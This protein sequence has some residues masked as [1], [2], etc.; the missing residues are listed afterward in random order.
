MGFDLTAK[1]SKQDA[2]FNWFA[3]RHILEATGAGYVLGFGYID[4]GRYVYSTGNNGS[5]MSNDGYKVTSFE[6]KCMAKCCRG[7][8]SVQRFLLEEAK[9]Q[10]I[11]QNRPYRDDD[12][13]DTW[14]MTATERFACFAENSGGFV[15]D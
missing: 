13:E 4:A 5:P 10:H 8:L 2:S 11:E 9:R 6:A 15:I 12:F 3:W 7:W 1:K 14:L